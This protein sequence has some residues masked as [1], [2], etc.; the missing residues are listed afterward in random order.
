MKKHFFIPVF[1]I[2]VC[3]GFCAGIKPIWEMKPEGVVI[4]FST[5]QPALGARLFWTDEVDTSTSPISVFPEYRNVIT[6]GEEK[7]LYQFLLPFEKDA[8]KSKVKPLTINRLI[9]FRI[10]AISKEPNKYPYISRS[11]DYVFRVVEKD[12]DKKRFGLVFTSE[13][14]ISC[15]DENQITISWKVNHPAR[16]AIFYKRYDKESFKR[17]DVSADLTQNG[18]FTLKNL[19]PD[20]LYEYFV[21]VYESDENTGDVIDSPQ[22]RFSTA[23]KKGDTSKHFQFA[24]FADTRANPASPYPDTSLNGVNVTAIENISGILRNFDP[25]FAI[26]VG[27]LISGYISDPAEI[28][29]QYSTWEQAVEPIRVSTPIYMTMGNHDTSAPY[30]PEVIPEGFKFAEQIFAERFILPQNGPEPEPG[31][32][33]HKEVVYSFDYG[34]CHFIALN[35][36]Y[37]FKR[38][39][40]KNDSTSRNIDPIQIEW[41][42]KDL[43]KNKS[44]KWIFIYFHDPAYPVSA[45]YKNSLDRFPETRDR[46]WELIDKYKVDAVF[47]GHEHIYARVIIDSSVNPRWKNSVPQIIAGRAGAPPYYRNEEVLW[48]NAVKSFSRDVHFLIAYVTPN[49]ISM[50]V[51]NEYG[52][53]I[54]S[55]EI[56]PKK[57]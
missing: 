13:P 19:S 34:P 6:D 57:R 8:Q 25:R 42:A 48:K 14:I 12:G 37:S 55:F 54:D 5:T 4:T 44:A 43:E 27:D 1:W 10:E 7:N 49:K 41:L 11:S 32:P 56:Y 35:S 46:L 52:G 47:C 24:V 45:H 20:T 33:P 3:V 17:V 30:V 40:S 50:E 53:T 39:A 23:I 16:S 31:R 28:D 18:V 22:T 26:C 38:T 29:N 2:L 21:R 51:I 36:S 9:H 15:V